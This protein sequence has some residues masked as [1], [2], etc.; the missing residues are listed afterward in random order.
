MSYI[1]QKDSGGDTYTLKAEQDGADVDLQLD[2]AAG[3][4]SEVKLKAGTNITLT[5]ASDTVTIDSA[6]A[7]GS[8][9]VNQVA[10]GD[11]SNAGDIKGSNNFI[12]DEGLNK[13][14]IGGAPVSG[15]SKLTVNSGSARDTLDLISTQSDAN[16]GP[17]L[18]MFRDSGAPLPGDTIAQI[19]FYGKD[20]GGNDQEYAR[21]SS[22]I[23]DETGATED[24]WLQ[25]GAAFAGN[26]QP[27]MMTIRGDVPEVVV[28]EGSGDVNFRVES[29]ANTNMLKVDGGQ[30]NVGIG[31]APANDDNKLQIFGDAKL[32]RDG[33][34]GSLTRTLTI[35]GAR[36]DVGADFAQLD[37]ANYDGGEYLGAQI[38]VRNNPDGVSD[39]EM[40]FRVADN[41]VLGER[42]SLGDEVVVNEPGNDIDFRVEGTSEQSLIRTN[43]AQN[44]VGIGT[45]PS[46]TV[47]RLD[48]Q[49]IATGTRT[50]RI[51]TNAPVA[52][53]GTPGPYL[54]LKRSNS[55]DVGQSNS[56]LAIFR[57]IGED[58]AS[59]DTVY[60]DLSAEVYNAT[61]G[62][63]DGVLKF[64]IMDDGVRTEYMRLTARDAAAPDKRGV[65][66][67][68]V[69]NDVSF[70]VE[71]DGVNPAFMV[72]AGQDNVGIGTQPESGVERLHV[73]GTGLTDMVVFE[74]T[75]EGSGASDG[76]DLILYNSATPTGANKFIGRLEYR[77]KNDAAA[78]KAYGSIQTFIQ[79]ETAGTEDSLMLFKTF[80]AGSSLEK[81]RFNLGGTE[82][83]ST[84][85]ASL[86][87]DVKTSSSTQ[88]SFFKTY[89]SATLADR[90][91]EVLR[92]TLTVS[93][94]PRTIT[95]D[96][97]YGSNVYMT[98]SASVINLPEGLPGMHL[99]VVNGG[100]TGLTMNPAAGQE[101]NGS[102]SAYSLTDGFK[103]TKVIC[104]A[105]GE[106]VASD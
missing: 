73:K 68:E 95:E 21:I 51:A 60:A 12:F 42:L 102:S 15:D 59:N 6:G 40:F 32:D 14:G 45:N 19:G 57:F 69:S 98:S 97:C 36:F 41:A 38:A 8:I 91:T 26:M 74:G 67:N 79:D 101:I 2:A 94:T 48:I 52:E 4:D 104:V 18:R 58:S 28:N 86:N 106:W 66:I 13:V 7:G 43:A 92:G 89:N 99:Q 61:N 82:L 72:D 11:P 31:G 17:N 93:A 87:F 63:E 34:T 35:E 56:Q 71:S 55:D 83:N 25:F 3:A 16:G 24:G 37:F 33:A 81:L 84:G 1:K 29:N 46:S 5:E 76:P 20:D 70:R 75:S 85:S 77:G 80:T 30:N 103:I 9:G 64:N 88:Q 96:Y 23:S 78:T 27:N 100:L 54:D 65:V 49:G 62:A 105:A 47:E 44:N 39:G 53:K 50:V 10:F 22:L 90:Y